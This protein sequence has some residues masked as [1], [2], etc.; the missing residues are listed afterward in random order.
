MNSGEDSA[1]PMISSS[2][3]ASHEYEGSVSV[4]PDS[5]WKIAAEVS[6]W[7]K[8]SRS[9]GSQLVGGFCIATGQYSSL[10]VSALGLILGGFDHVE[11]DKQDRDQ[12][13]SERE[14]GGAR[15][16]GRRQG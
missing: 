14:G 10:C 1:F 13:D 3:S 16:K 5:S 9:L 15:E 7:S 4:S 12:V 11:V 8:L 6:E 2:S